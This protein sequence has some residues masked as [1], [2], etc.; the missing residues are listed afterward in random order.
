MRDEYL[1]AGV[2]SASSDADGLH[3]AA[4]T[5]LNVDLIVSWN[6]KHIVHFARIRGFNA[7]NRLNGYKE[8]EIYSPWEV[9]ES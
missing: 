7:V 5:V 4:V 2:L 8:V 6:F 1:E 3:V 9:I